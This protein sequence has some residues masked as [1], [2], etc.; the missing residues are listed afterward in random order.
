MS[1]PRFALVVFF[2]I[3]PDHVEA[4]RRRVLQQASDS[5]RLEPDCHQFDVAIDPAEPNRVV[6]YETYTDAAAFD[7]HTKTEH[8]AD[9]QATVGDMIASKQVSKLDLVSQHDA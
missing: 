8:F 4:F 3:K 5:L 7:T 2:D 6:L 1:Q 9:F